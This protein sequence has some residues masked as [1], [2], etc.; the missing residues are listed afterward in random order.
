MKTALKVLK[1]ATGILLVLVSGVVIYVYANAGRTYEAPFPN[2]VASQDSS[3]IAR[4]RYLVYGPAHCSG[5][6]VPEAEHDRL[7]RGEHV[8]LTGGNAF[9]LPMGT[10]YTANITPDKDVGIGRYS[11]GQIARALRYGVRHDGKALLDFMPYYDLSVEDMTAVI[12]FLRS[13]KPVN[14]PVPES[15]WNFLGKALIA[16][17]LIK[18]MGDGDVPATIPQDST[19]EYGKYIAR[20]VAN[21]VGCHTN[22]DMMTGGFTSPDFSGQFVMDVEDANGDAKYI[23]SPNLTPDPA[24]GRITDWTQSQFIS[25]FRAGDI[26][27]GSPMPWPAFG[28]MSD[29][30]LAAL[31]K[32]LSQ[33]EPVV[34]EIEIPVGL[35]D[36]PPSSD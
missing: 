10:L 25:R 29:M 5:C 15:E 32:Y 21:C 14:K 9:E 27:A 36:E 12:S 23:V 18:P 16:F 30:E 33:L 4:G 3:I 24:T 7:D 6:H 22:R 2:I 26:I 20:S 11:D 17:G 8:A 35:I 28:R 31:Y 19:A 13:Q 34:A 1:W